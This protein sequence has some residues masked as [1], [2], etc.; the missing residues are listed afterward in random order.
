[1]IPSDL[2][3][4]VHLAALLEGPNQAPSFTS[5]GVVS[6]VISKREDDST[7]LAHRMGFSSS[8]YFATV[9][10][11]ITGISPRKLV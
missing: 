6:E 3:H 11:H 10:K 2:L 1:L 8:Q 7:D 4:P 9:F 5:S